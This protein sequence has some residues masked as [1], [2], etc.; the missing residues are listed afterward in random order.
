M[1]KRSSIAVL[2]SDFEESPHVYTFSS[3][4][5]SPI[6]QQKLSTI[7]FEFTENTRPGSFLSYQTPATHFS[8]LSNTQEQLPKLKSESLTRIDDKIIKIREEY[9]PPNRLLDLNIPVDLIPG[10]EKDIPT[11]RWCPYCK[12]ETATEIFFTHSSNTFWASVGI[13]F[14]GGILGCFL[15]PYMV[16]SCKDGHA[17]CHRC[18]H[19]VN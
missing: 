4:S 9:E 19:K 1:T 16:D 6:I 2:P 12:C 13:F 18:K 5:N 10:F 17:R 15:I 11:L 8:S 14:S 3:Q 7:P